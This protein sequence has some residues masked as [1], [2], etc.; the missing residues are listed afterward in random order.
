MAFPSASGYGNLPNGN[1]SPVI[2][3]KKA[4][5]AFR[6]VS[7]VEDITNTDYIGEIA[8]MGDTV[9]I[10][11]EPEITVQPYLRGTS[12][13]TQDLIDDNITLIVDQANYY[14]F[15]VDDIESKQS[16]MNWIDL[17]SNRAA[18][19]LKDAYDA[20]VL[21]YMSGQAQASHQLG[22]PTNIIQVSADAGA[23]FSPLGIM[24][25]MARLLDE[26]EV[27]TDHRFFVADPVF[28][29][30]LMDEDSKLVNANEMGDGQS[31]LLNGKVTTKTL[32]GFTLYKSTNLPKDGEG[33]AGSVTDGDYGVIVAGHLSSTATAMQLTKTEN[34]RDPQSFA[35]IVRGMQVYGR[36]TL[37]PEALVTAHWASNA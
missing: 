28:Y 31:V 22:S 1:W 15:K 11:K 23:D 35:D 9:E 10:I 20:E 2:Y 16:H 19:R 14:A 7:V 21:D 29:E 13:Q 27:P 37:R 4:Q 32:R 30:M 12:V 17:A 25:R 5:K 6:R 26:E 33:S 36:K 24:N 18:Y 8:N 34:F 3:S